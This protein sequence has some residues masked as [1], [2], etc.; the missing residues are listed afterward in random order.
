M[1]KQYA[2]RKTLADNRPRV[3]GRF[4]RNDEPNEIPK[5]PC[6]I[7]DEDEVDFWVIISLLLLINFVA[8][9]YININEFNVKY[10]DDMVLI[11]LWSHLWLRCK[12]LYCKKMH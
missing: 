3:R 7:R 2:C 8:F 4:A 9:Y 10:S 5:A 11:T 6:L 1:W 12:P